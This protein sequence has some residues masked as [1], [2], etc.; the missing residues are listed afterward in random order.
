MEDTGKHLTVRG[1]SIV[2][3]SSITCPQEGGGGGEGGGGSGA[4]RRVEDT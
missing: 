1:V 3:V 2:T 4:E